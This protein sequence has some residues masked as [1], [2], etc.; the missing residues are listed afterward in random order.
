MTTHAIDWSAQPLGKIADTALAKQLG[1]TTAIVVHT[2]RRLGIPGLRVV[3]DS[4][5]LAG[6]GRGEIDWSKQP[7]GELPDLELAK[8]L[9]THRARVRLARIRRGIPLFVEKDTSFGSG[10]AGGEL[11]RLREARWYRYPVTADPCRYC[12]EARHMRA[13][14]GRSN[15]MVRMTDQGPACARHYLA[16]PQCPQ[17]EAPATK[18]GGLCEG[19]TTKAIRTE[20]ELCGWRREVPQML[21]SVDRGDVETVRRGIRAFEARQEKQIGRPI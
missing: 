11:E 14:K 3:K 13:L 5:R 1:V 21:P 17:C 19:C 9:G 10:P 8:I 18:D 15:F 16:L 6:P 4:E 2:R 20:R 12:T 7:L